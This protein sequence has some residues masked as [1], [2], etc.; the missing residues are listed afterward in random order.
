MHFF[1]TVIPTPTLAVRGGV[2]AVVSVCVCPQAARRTKKKRTARANSNVFA[3][4]DQDQIAE[5]QEVR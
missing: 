5:F 4:F 1:P 2:D 3:R